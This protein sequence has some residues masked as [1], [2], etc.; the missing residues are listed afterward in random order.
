VKKK[1]TYYWIISQ[2]SGEVLEVEGG[3]IDND[4]RI[5]QSTKKSRDDCNVSFAL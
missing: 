2:D 5:I 1:M 4:V 3:S